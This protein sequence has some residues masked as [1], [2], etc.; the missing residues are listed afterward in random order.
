M[1][2]IKADDVKA[3]QEEYDCGLNMAKQVLEQKAANDIV[4]DMIDDL[5][6]YGSDR[7][8]E[9]ITKQNQL[10]KYLINRIL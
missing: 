6:F 1:F 4:D 10:L 2:N 7:Y 9:I 8:Y 5:E 3:A